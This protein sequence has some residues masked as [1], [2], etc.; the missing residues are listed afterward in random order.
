MNEELNQKISQFLDDELDYDDTLR[1]L[2]QI[3]TQPEL[4][5]TLNRYEAISH[6]LKTGIFLEIGADFSAAIHQKIK[7][8]P[9]HLRPEN[10]RLPQPVAHKYKVLAMAA[11]V[12][13][14]AVLTTRNMNKPSEAVKTSS[15]T[16]AQTVQPALPVRQSSNS[17]AYMPEIK[18]Y[19][20]NTRINDYLQAHNYT[21]SIY[22]N[23]EADLTSLNRVTAYHQK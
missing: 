13:V 10:P 11:S 15:L 9:F 8:E 19:P 3:Q 18:Q 2:Q 14:V 1:L 17:V 7:T 21:N 23:D 22:V 4:N 6:T 20:I 12:A 5:Q 16:Q